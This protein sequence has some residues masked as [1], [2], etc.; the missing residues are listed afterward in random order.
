[1]V[2]I[3]C[4]SNSV[5]TAQFGLT[6]DW[7]HVPD[8]SAPTCTKRH[9]KPL[10]CPVDRRLNGAFIIFE[11]YKGLRNVVKKIETFVGWMIIF[12]VG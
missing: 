6:S 12:Y 7:N 2:I 3:H 10:S 11:Q 1:M 8:S 9:R 4:P 5:L